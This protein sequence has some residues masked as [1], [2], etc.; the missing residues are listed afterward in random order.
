MTHNDLNRVL[1]C[2]RHNSLQAYA[3]EDPALLRSAADYIE[4]FR[5]V[6]L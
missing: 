3:D 1:L 5:K 6:T 4:R 2:K